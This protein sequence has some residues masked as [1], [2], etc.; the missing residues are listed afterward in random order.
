MEFIGDIYDTNNLESKIEEFLE[1]VDLKNKKNSLIIDLSHGMKK[2]VG[3]IGE[4]IHEPD[5]L[6]LDEPFAGID[7]VS[8][9]AIKNVLKELTERGVTIFLSTHILEVAEKICKDVAIIDSGQIIARGEINNLRRKAELEEKS[10]LEDIFLKLV[11][12]AEEVRL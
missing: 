7:P 1:L 12:E 11:E 5:I 10:T 2:K 4:L 9:K 8:S 3:L 6:F